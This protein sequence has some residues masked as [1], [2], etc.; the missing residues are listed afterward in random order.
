V[1]GSPIIVGAIPQKENSSSS[2]RAIIIPLRTAER[3]LKSFPI[4]YSVEI[5]VKQRTF[6]GDLLERVENIYPYFP[7]E[8]SL[9]Q[10]RMLWMTGETPVDPRHGS[11]LIDK[12]LTFLIGR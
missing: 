3:R 6:L 12:R 5:G 8:F 10:L 9:T 4:N 1:T 7:I 2:I 11:G